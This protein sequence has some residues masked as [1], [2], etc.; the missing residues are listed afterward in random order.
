M[1]HSSAPAQHDQGL[2]ACAQRRARQRQQHCALGPSVM[3]LRSVLCCWVR[4]GVRVT[5]AVSI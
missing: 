5:G 3:A 4:T 2:V 1:R